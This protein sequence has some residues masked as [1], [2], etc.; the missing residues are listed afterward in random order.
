MSLRMKWFKC[1][2]CQKEFEELVDL[3][4]T[5]TKCECDHTAELSDDFI[6]QIHHQ[7][8]D[9]KNVS[10]SIHNAGE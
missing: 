3:K 8:W 6:K 7:G 9:Y 5:T 1:S 2:F 10:W 4:D